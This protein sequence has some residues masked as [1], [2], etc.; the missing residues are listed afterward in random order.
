MM[1]V[2]ARMRQTDG[3]SVHPKSLEHRDRVLKEAGMRCVA[4]TVAAPIQRL[5]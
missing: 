5:V 1:E 4:M 3:G 2:R